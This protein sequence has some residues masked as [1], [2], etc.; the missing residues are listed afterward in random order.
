MKRLLITMVAL[1]GTIAT[2]ANSEVQKP[3]YI[4]NGKVATIDEVKYLGDDLESMTVLTNKKDVKE[5][6]HLGDTSNGVIVITLKSTEEEDMPFIYADV[7]PQFMGGDLL[8][9]R[10]WVMQNVR[11]PE[12]A[13]KEGKEDM[14]VVQFSVNRHG[15]I[16]YDRINILQSEYPDIFAEEVKRVISSSP[17]WT[18][19]FNNGYAV[20]VT[21]T[22]PI[23]FKLESKQ[24]VTPAVKSD[25]ENQIVIMALDS[26]KQSKSGLNPVYIIDGIPS[27]LEQV[28]A[29]KPEEIK[30]VVVYRDAKMFSYYKDYGNVEDGV[31]IIR[32]N[33]LDKN[34]ENTP[35]TLPIFMNTSTEAFQ[36]WLFENLRYPE[37]LRDKNLAAHYVVK[38][39]VDSA[40]YV[41]IMEIKC[42]KGTAHKSF[43]D[44]ITRV[45]LSSPR[46][47][48]GMKN[49]KAVSCQ[50][51]LPVIFG[52]M[53]I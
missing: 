51:S 48:P 5:F 9:F 22:L 13:M 37:Q 27:T 39:K 6:E 14:V 44:E 45:M 53:D 30:D 4:I 25:N 21:L 16:D 8:A 32:T 49:G 47:T 29:L 17:R 26:D 2:Y 38:F 7:M 43:E 20:S 46:W 40:G 28:N 11:Y 31:F 36:R 1:I 41:V 10:S 3:L 52:S 12:T 34:I 23:A 42:I 18:P 33:S 19:G 24:G 50:L 35:D 15:Y